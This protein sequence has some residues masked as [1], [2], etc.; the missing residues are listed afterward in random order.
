MIYCTLTVFCLKG[1]HAFWSCYYQITQ[2][3]NYDL[4]LLDVV[5]VMAPNT[6]KNYSI[7]HDA[8]FEK[9][10][11]VLQI[12]LHFSCL[13]HNNVLWNLLWLDFVC[14]QWHTFSKRVYT[15][16]HILYIF[17]SLKCMEIEIRVRFIT[18]RYDWHCYE[19][20]SVQFNG[21]S[22]VV[23]VHKKDFKTKYIQ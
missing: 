13:W 22:M 10:W 21:H 23:F 16:F 15:P 3:L 8:I 9:T 4:N 20:N 12:W 2:W 17:T 19:F 5:L 18:V 1:V 11:N 14:L 6:L 7:W